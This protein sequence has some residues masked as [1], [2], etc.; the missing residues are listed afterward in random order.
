MS[1][2]IMSNADGLIQFHGHSVA[3]GS[4]R[5]SNNAG[6]NS[7]VFQPLYDIVNTVLS[8]GYEVIYGAESFHN[9]GKD[10]KDRISN[11]ILK[12]KVLI[13]KSKK[14]LLIIILYLRIHF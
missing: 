7:G 10:E 6:N 13:L 8:Y 9:N 2:I 4:D 3:F 14:I 1:Y 5:Y 11:E 12:S